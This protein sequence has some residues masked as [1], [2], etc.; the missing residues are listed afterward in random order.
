M[1][2]LKKYQGNPKKSP[3]FHFHVETYTFR[4]DTTY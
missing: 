2:I 3:S 1:A 4:N